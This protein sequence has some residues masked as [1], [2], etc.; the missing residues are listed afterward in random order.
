MTLQGSQPQ[1]GGLEQPWERLR[2]AASKT[3]PRGQQ[4]GWWGERFF[5]VGLA[6]GH[7]AEEPDGL[8][9]LGSQRVGH[10]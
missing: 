8:Q 7:R 4:R 2:L 5:P 9:S 1:G 3:L 6:S 10:D